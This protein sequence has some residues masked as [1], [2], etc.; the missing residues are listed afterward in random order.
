MGKVS[1]RQF[2]LNG[3]L[4]VVVL[5]LASV[6]TLAQQKAQPIVI[7]APLSTIRTTLLS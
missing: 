4:A 2:F 6:D 1:R 3:F 7:G 5:S